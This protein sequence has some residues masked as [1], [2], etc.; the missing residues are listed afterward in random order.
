MITLLMK[1]LRA[2]VWQPQSK[3]LLSA[4]S[5]AVGRQ[6]GLLWYKDL[7]QHVNGEFSMAVFQAN[8]LL[9]DRSQTESGSLSLMDSGPFGSF[10]GVYDGHGGPEAAQYI[11]DHLFGHI[12]S[13]I[14]RLEK[15]F[16][17][18]LTV[19]FHGSMVFCIN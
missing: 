15:Y 1:F 4:G 10:V 8:K 9:E 17:C 18:F 5:D 19:D 3:R 12:K 7:G 13:K 6:D 2:C 16:F 14:L 11:T